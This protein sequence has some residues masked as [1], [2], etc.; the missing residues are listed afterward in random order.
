MKRYFERPKRK[1]RIFLLDVL[2]QIISASAIHLI[3]VILSVMIDGEV[4]RDTRDQC[5][6]YLVSVLMDSS[7]GLIIVVLVLRMTLRYTRRYKLDYLEQGNYLSRDGE[8]IL[9]NYSAQTAMWVAAN[10]LVN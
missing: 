9:Y 8:V 10:L 2:K 1:F 7:I 3:N 6:S 5:A 4:L